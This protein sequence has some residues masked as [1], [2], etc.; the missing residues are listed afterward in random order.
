MK[1]ETEVD[2]FLGN[3]NPENDE[4]NENPDPFNEIPVEEHKEGE[5]EG[6]PAKEKP[7]AFHKDPKV[8]RYVEKQIAK[9]LE[10]RTEKEFVREVETDTDD[11]YERLIG[12]DSAEKI[13]MIKEAKARDAKLLEQAEERAFN[14]ITAEQQRV[15]QE[16]IKATEELETALDDIEDYFNVDITSNDPVARKTRVDFIKFVEKIAPKN[17]KG[18]II[19]YP[20]MNSAFE[21]F[22]ETRKSAPMSTRAKDLA[23]R[24]ISKSSEV[25][26]KPQERITFDDMDNILGRLLN[27]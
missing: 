14:R 4:F 11:Y 26:S 22:Q 21:T 10:G 27:Q 1:K 9:A 18:E 25:S 24:S 7:V 19:D 2:E 15:L 5:S 6:E 13:A 12:N 20:D 23:S 8:Q 16:D 3:L 17:S